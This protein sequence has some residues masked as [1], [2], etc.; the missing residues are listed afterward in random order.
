MKKR[1]GAALALGIVAATL[2]TPSAAAGGMCHP[3][4]GTRMRTST[5]PAVNI[6]KCA[7]EQTVVYIDPGDTVRWTNKDVFPHSVTGAAGSW[8][9]EVMLSQDDEVAH[10]FKAE[11]VYPYYCV[12]HPS[13]VGAVVVGDATKAVTL[14]GGKAD[15]APAALDAVAPA[16]AGEPV[17]KTTGGYVPVA[18]GL[19]TVIGLGLAIG[20][21]RLVMGRR[22]AAATPI[23]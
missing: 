3:G 6:D 9:D 15:V 11:G 7:F 14:T 4:T 1:I 10:T 17:S 16:D 19:V 20:A 2:L 23:P 13:M 8:G 22:R 18:I 12:L 5:E 21:T